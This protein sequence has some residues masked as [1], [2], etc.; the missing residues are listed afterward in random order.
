MTTKILILGGYGLFGGMISQNLCGQENIQVIIAGRSLEKAQRFAA[1][2]PQT[3]HAPDVAVLDIEGGFAEKLAAIAPDIVIHTCGPFQGQ[4]YGVARACIAQG[5][6]YIDLAD[7]RDFVAHIDRL[8]HDARAKNVS[9][10][11]GASSVPCLT[12]AV[13]DAYLPRFQQ[14]YNI[15]AGISTAQRTNRGKATTAAMLSYAGKSFETKINGHMH[16]VYGWLGLTRRRY[17]N[18]GPRWLADCDVPDLALFPKR[19]PH[20]G[21][22]RFRAGL[23]I[24][25]MQWVLSA[26][27][28]LVKAGMLSSLER[29]APALLKISRLFDFLGSST[30]AFHLRLSGRGL[31]GKDSTKTFFLLARQ[32]DGLHIPTIPAI[33][34]AKR[35]AAKDTALPAGAM[36]CLGLVTLDEYLAALRPLAIDV[37]RP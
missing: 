37:H 32:G 6:H 35:L 13:I 20:V 8:D 22:I 25:L 16:S 7:A 30:S 1:S 14:V 27:A 18:I 33:L 36:P 17:P 5:C 21:T 26:L 19:Y 11:S 29:F 15:D 23:E 31:D 12:A 34:L 4:D 10:I 9:I 24:S 2:C 3:P 28:F